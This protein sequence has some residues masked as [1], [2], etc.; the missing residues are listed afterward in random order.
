VAIGARARHLKEDPEAL[1]SLDSMFAD[2]RN[3][4]P[5]ELRAGEPNDIDSVPPTSANHV[6]ATLDSAVDLVSSLLSETETS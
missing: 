4:L 2:L 1:A 6:R 3:K 5:A